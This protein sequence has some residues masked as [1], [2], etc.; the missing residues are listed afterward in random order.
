MIFSKDR[1]WQ[2]AEISVLWELSKQGMTVREIALRLGRS[3]KS[4]LRKAEELKIA[5]P[6]SK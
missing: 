4:I 3:E 6:P 1:P 2:Y 5:L